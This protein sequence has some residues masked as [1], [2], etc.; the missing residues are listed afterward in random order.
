MWT[1]TR[2]WLFD[3]ESGV[4]VKPSLVAAGS[5]GRCVDCPLRATF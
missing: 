1:K 4:F 5:S 3:I 2:R